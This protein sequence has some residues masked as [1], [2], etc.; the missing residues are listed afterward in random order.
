MIHISYDGIETDKEELIETG[1]SYI[2][3]LRED[4]TGMLDQNGTISELTWDE[5]NI[6]LDDIKNPYVLSGDQ[7]I[8]EENESEIIFEKSRS[9]EK[10]NPDA[11]SLSAEKITV[12]PAV[13]AQELENYSNSDFSMKIPQ[14]WTVETTP[15]TAGMFH[16]VRVY[17]PECPVNQI[18]FQIKYQ[19][20]FPN[21]DTRA[22]FAVNFPEMMNLPVLYDVSTEGFFSVFSEYADSFGSEPALGDFRMPCIQNFTVQEKFTSNSQMSNLAVSP[23]MLRADFTQDGIEGEGMF[24]ADLVSFGAESG[25]GY[26]MAY[27]IAG[28]SAS[29]GSLQDWEDMLSRS[30]GSIEY[31]QEFVSY[32]MSQS[33]QTVDAS[34]QLSQAAS[35]MQDSIMSSWQN[36]NISQDIMSQKQSDATLGYERVMDVETGEIY[37]TENGFTDWYDG[38]RYKA[39]TDEQYA[40]GVEGELV[41]K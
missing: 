34:Q 33:D 23:A 18:F 7:M 26:Y 40:E 6:I 41:W 12:V 9:R 22:L 19:P 37:R 35:A 1:T 24:S 39:I 25:M 38:E 8:I 10:I 20:L 17:D 3:T 16:A 30:L 21:E 28:I 14:G 31:S 36:R 11:N 27:N 4:R 5:D 29:K 15:S 2:L 32:A 13:Y